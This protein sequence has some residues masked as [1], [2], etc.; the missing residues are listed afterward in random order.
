MPNA[1]GHSFNLRGLPG[2]FTAPDRFAR[3]FILK[4][5]ALLNAPLDPSATADRSAPIGPSR[6]GPCE[7]GEAAVPRL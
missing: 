4:Q 5:H 6:S 2:A 3:T 1:V 7:P